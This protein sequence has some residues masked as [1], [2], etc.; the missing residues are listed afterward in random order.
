MVILNGYTEQYWKTGEI[1]DERKFENLGVLA[2]SFTLKYVNEE[3]S[4]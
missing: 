2:L 1:A 4:N 3:F